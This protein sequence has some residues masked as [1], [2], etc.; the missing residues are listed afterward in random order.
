[1]SAAIILVMMPQQATYNL[2]NMKIIDHSTTKKRTKN[3]TH[4]IEFE[5]FTGV[6]I[7]VLL[8]YG[9]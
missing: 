4:Y 3:K 1:M 6:K 9:L 8:S 7:N 5:V 2:Q